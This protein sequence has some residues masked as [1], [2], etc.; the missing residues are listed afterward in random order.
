MRGESALATALPAARGVFTCGSELRGQE[1]D[2]LAERVD[3][4]RQLALEGLSCLTHALGPLEGAPQGAVRPRLGL[5][6]DRIGAVLGLPL[7]VVGLDLCALLDRLR[8]R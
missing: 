1:V 4:L 5:A 7:D 3:H 6:H 2:L 8:A